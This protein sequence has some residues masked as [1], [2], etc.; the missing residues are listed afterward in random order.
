MGNETS[1]DKVHL[2]GQ[3]TLSINY[4][5]TSFYQVIIL[6]IFIKQIFSQIYHCRYFK[7]YALITT[8]PK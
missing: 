7:M 3:P 8:T 1:P 5:V 6:V 2:Y 4:S